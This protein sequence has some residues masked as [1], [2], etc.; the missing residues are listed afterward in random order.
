MI[1]YSRFDAP[2]FDS[3]TYERDYDAVMNSL[4]DDGN[5]VTLQLSATRRAVMYR[6]AAGSVICRKFERIA[7]RMTRVT[8]FRAS[9]D[10]GIEVLIN[11]GI[12]AL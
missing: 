5:K 1:G 4:I 2:V 8:A 10:E 12:A 3:N 11:W 6:T 9:E 7:G